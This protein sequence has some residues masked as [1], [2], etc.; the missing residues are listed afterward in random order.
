MI[1]LELENQLRQTDKLI[2][3]FCFTVGYI[4]AC[5]PDLVDYIKRK[6][7]ND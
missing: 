1:I 3:M 4:T 2:I 5:V 6:V 7:H